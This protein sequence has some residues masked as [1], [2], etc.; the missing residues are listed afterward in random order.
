M[1]FD[2]SNLITVSV[3]PYIGH[4]RY[5]EGF[6]IRSGLYAHQIMFKV[7]KIIVK[8]TLISD[9]SEYCNTEIKASKGNQRTVLSVVL[10]V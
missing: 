3:T 9:E 10:K 6:W 2:T 8:I 1:R 4:R 7:S 5:S